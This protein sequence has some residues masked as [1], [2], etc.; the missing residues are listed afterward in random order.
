MPKMT[1]P[2]GTEIKHNGQYFF[3]VEEELIMF[4]VLK[5]KPGLP[6]GKSWLC[7]IDFAKNEIAPINN[8]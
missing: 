6:S 4:K 1:Y 3:T 8:Q 7:R 2:L 5:Q